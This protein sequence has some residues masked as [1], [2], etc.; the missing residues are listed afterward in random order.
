MTLAQA[1]ASNLDDAKQVLKDPLTGRRVLIPFTS[2]AF[3]EGTLQPTLASGK[4]QVLVKISKRHFLESN[5]SEAIE[6]LEKRIQAVQKTV[7]AV[8][9]A[10][11]S[12]PA[13]ARPSSPSGLPFFEIREEFDQQGNEIRSEAINVAKELE[14][15]QRNEDDKVDA[16]IRATP[17]SD[18]VVVE[19][20]AKTI[21]ALSE[22][23]YQDLASRLEEL[24]MMEEEA[25]AKKKTNQTSSKRLQGS[26][27]SKGFLN[28]KKPAKKNPVKSAVAAAN[29]SLAAAAAVT[30]QA[31]A[32]RTAKKVGFQE[33]DNQIKEIPRVGERSV[34]SRTVVPAEAPPSRQI[35]ASVF[36]GVIQER[37][38]AT[39]VVQER[40]AAHEPKKK[41]SRFAQQRLDQQQ[42]AAAA[43]RKV[44]RFAQERQQQLR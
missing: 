1:S 42:E 35:E 37:P 33:K 28:K 44:S 38:A 19:E 30:E 32:P 3:F 14:Y 9:T 21:A 15:L 29:T 4:E 20:G 31:A 17:P 27:W 2:K 39:A 36:N 24:A 11:R 18:V 12:A 43:P 25:E 40:T 5:R 10:P 23:E 6:L 41:L 8:T 26:G 34:P 16:A 7:R 13:A 22:E